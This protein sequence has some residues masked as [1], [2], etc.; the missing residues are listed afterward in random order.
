MTEALAPEGTIHRSHLSVSPTSGEL[1][2]TA[3]AAAESTA[4]AAAL[5]AGAADAP[6]T[7]PGQQRERRF[8]PSGAARK[9]GALSANR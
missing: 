5:A 3:R 8:L 4:P 2:P 6:A 7:L 1:I 9:R